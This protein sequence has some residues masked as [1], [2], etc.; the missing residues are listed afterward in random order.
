MRS[1]SSSPFACFSKSSSVVLFMQVFAVQGILPRSLELS[2][3]SG[4]RDFESLP[5]SIVPCACYQ[6]NGTNV[7]LA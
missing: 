7:C 4:A 1:V 2:F 6:L 3:A 5:R